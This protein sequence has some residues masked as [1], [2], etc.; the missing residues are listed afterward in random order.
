MAQELKAR[1]VLPEDRDSILAP[2]NRQLTTAHNSSL[3]G[4]DA[5]S[6]LLGLR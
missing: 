5:L 3:K 6:S 1:T 4:P 2:Y